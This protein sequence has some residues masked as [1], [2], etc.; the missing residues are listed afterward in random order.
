MLIFLVF[1]EPA[2]GFFRPSRKIKP[3]EKAGFEFGRTASF[4]PNPNKPGFRAVVAWESPKSNAFVWGTSEVLLEV[5]F[6]DYSI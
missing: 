5:K 2:L 1:T 4:V 6:F 3:L